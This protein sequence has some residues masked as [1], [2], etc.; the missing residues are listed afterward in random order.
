MLE[1]PESKLHCSRIGRV[2]Y[3]PPEPIAIATQVLRGPRGADGTATAVEEFIPVL[4]QTM[5][6]LKQQI[7]NLQTAQVY[8]NGQKQKYGS[9][10][11][12]GSSRLI[13]EWLNRDYVLDDEDILE[14]YY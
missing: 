13:L 1:K 12:I 10:Y 3:R 5:F 11:T 4:G 7:N 9:A 14:V 2:V 8:L 6:N